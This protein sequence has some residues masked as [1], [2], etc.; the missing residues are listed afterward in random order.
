MDVVAN[1]RTGQAL[2]IGTNTTNRDASDI[3]GPKTPTVSFSSSIEVHCLICP[4]NYSYAL[5]FVDA[6]ERNNI[7]IYSFGVAGDGDPKDCLL[8]FI[9]GNGKIIKWK[10][11]AAIYIRQEIDSNYWSSSTHMFNISNTHFREYQKWLYPWLRENDVYNIFEGDRTPR[12]FIRDSLSFFISRGEKILTLVVPDIQ[13]YNLEYK[14]M[15]ALSIPELAEAITW[16]NEM[17]DLDFGSVR[18]LVMNINSEGVMY[19]HQ[20]V[21]NQDKYWILRG[22]NI[23]A[24]HFKAESISSIMEKAAEVDYGN[25]VDD[26]VVGDMATSRPIHELG[27]VVKSRHSDSVDQDASVIKRNDD[28][29]VGKRIIRTS[30]EPA[31]FGEPSV[32]QEPT[33]E[34]TLAIQNAAFFAAQAVQGNCLAPIA[35][36]T[37]PAGTITGSTIAIVI[38][39][40]AIIFIILIVILV[41]MYEGETRPHPA[42]TVTVTGTGATHG[43][44]IIP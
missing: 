16:F 8:P 23:T 7:R 37:Q 40:I 17:R 28:R 12:C 21:D 4:V 22:V 34:Q 29:V 33:A 24:V 32:K 15:T 27:K 43:P 20:H 11:R 25:T 26:G 42:S 30:K 44:P 38:V 1:R 18:S 14:K 19:Y 2:S 5:C 9:E 36:A 3:V 13:T 35:P 31:L 6:K 41:Y 10:N 39:F